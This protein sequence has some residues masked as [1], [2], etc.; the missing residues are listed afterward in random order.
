MFSEGE[1]DEVDWD[2]CETTDALD[3]KTGNRGLARASICDQKF[4]S[5]TQ[6]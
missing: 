5:S 4:S 2:E 3:R 1:L 6:P